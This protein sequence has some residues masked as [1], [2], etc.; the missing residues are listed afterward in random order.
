MSRAAATLTLVAALL[1]GCAA[2]APWDRGTLAH[3]E[4]RDDADPDGAATA[5]HVAGAREAAL[6]PSGSGGGGCGCN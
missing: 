2:V 6:D 5:A 3:P 1:G 4:M